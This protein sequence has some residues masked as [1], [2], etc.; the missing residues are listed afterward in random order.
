MQS[1]AR[2]TNTALAKWLVPY[3]IVASLQYQFT[4]DGLSYASPFVLMTFRYVFTGVIFYFIGGRKIPLDRD[5][6][7]VAGFSSAS[8][9]LWAVG[10]TYVSA[11]DSAILS[12][13]MPLFSIPIAFVVIREKVLVREL[14]GA[15]VGF[16]G[17]IVYSLTLSHGSQAVGAM[18]T[19][20][21]AVFWA[22]YSVYYRKLRSRN[23]VPILTTQF[24][25]GSIP[26]AVG[27]LFYPQISPG[28]NLLVDLTYIVLFSG[29]VL[30]S[31]WNG[32]LRRGRVGRITTMAFAVPAV[33]ILIDSIRTFTLPSSLAVIGGVM[34]FIGVFI[35]N[36]SRDSGEA[37]EGTTPSHS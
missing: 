9:L 16:S 36:W 19:L 21:G 13:T 8:T 27:S 15:L 31:L 29:V 32:L 25:I 33:T 10:L 12:Y 24:L 11:G 1:Q 3:V 35:A 4:K 5:A 26:G 34:M 28:I 37:G 7:L 20:V 22:A 6:L 23:P 2:Q 18:F 17:V 14:L 30:F